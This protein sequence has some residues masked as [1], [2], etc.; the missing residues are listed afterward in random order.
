MKQHYFTSL[1]NKLA[2][3]IGDALTEVTR[4][5]NQGLYDFIRGQFAHDR[6]I[7]G[8]MVFQATYPWE[9][10][11][12]RVD[13]LDYLDP[14][15]RKHI[16][17]GEKPN[18]Y[19]PYKHQD[20]AF[21]SALQVDSD[22]QATVITTGT[23]SGKTEC[24]LTPL[25][26]D[27]VANAD[28]DDGVRA[29]MLYPLNALIN[30]QK[31]RL[32][33]WSQPFG[34]QIRFALYNGNTPYDINSENLRANL[35]EVSDRK[36]IRSAPPQILV[37]NQ[38][39]LEY[40]LVRREDKPILEKSK[41][42]LKWIILDEAHTYIGSQSADIAML[43]KR[44]LLEFEV[45]IE[46]VRFVIT[47][48]TV[49]GE[50]GIASLK[51]FI[52]DLTGL[53]VDKVNVISGN[54]TV[55]ALL[56]PSNNLSLEDVQSHSDAKQVLAQNDTV[57]R[58]FEYMTEGACSAKPLS[59]I[60][61]HMGMTDKQAL[62]W[63]DLVSAHEIMPLKG[64]LFVNTISGI[65]ACINP[66][67]HHKNIHSSDWEYGK[68]FT[69]EVS[70]CQCGAPVYRLVSC[71]KCNQHYHIA[72]IVEKDN[73]QYLVPDK[74]TGSMSDYEYISVQVD[75]DVDD[76]HDQRTYQD[77]QSKSEKSPSFLLTAPDVLCSHVIKA[78]CAKIDNARRVGTEGIVIDLYEAD[79]CPGCGYRSARGAFYSLWDYGAP[80]VLS[81]IVPE[82]FD[83]LSNRNDKGENIYQQGRRFISFTDNRQRTAQINVRLNQVAEFTLC[84]AL[85]Y[86]TIHRSC[87]PKV[88]EE[89]LSDKGL[90]TDDQKIK[91]ALI[92]QYNA[93]RSH[94]P[95]MTYKKLVEELREH[96]YFGKISPYIQGKS[97]DDLNSL[98]KSDIA[99]MLVNR[100]FL[101]YLPSRMTLETTGLCYVTF[102]Y[103]DDID[104]DL[105]QE[106]LLIFGGDAEA[107]ALR[108]QFV[109]LYMQEVIRHENSLPMSWQQR[110][111]LGFDYYGGYIKLEIVDQLKDP[112]SHIEKLRNHRLIHYLLWVIGRKDMLERKP[113]TVNNR[114]KASDEFDYQ[115]QMLFKYVY[116]C[117]HDLIKKHDDS[118]KYF[119]NTDKMRFGLVTDTA[120]CP[121]W[122]VS[123]PYHLKCYTPFYN[124]K[125]IPLDTD[126]SDVLESLKVKPVSIPTYAGDLGD[127]NIFTQDEH[128][129]WLEG[130]KREMDRNKLWF[131]HHQIIFTKPLEDI[132]FVSREHT[133]QIENQQLRNYEDAFNKGEINVLNCSTTMEMGIDLDGIGA[134]VMTN[135]PPH[136]ANYQ[137][138]A[139]RAGR[140][141]E[142][143]TFTLTVCNQTAKDQHIFKHPMALFENKVK[144]KVDL[145]SYTLVRKHINAYLLSC[146]FE[147][148]YIADRS[149]DKFDCKTFF[150]DKTVKKEQTQK[151][152]T[153]YQSFLA[154]LAGV[155]DSDSIRAPIDVWMQ[156]VPSLKGKPI[157]KLIAD[158]QQ[159]IEKVYAEWKEVIDYIH[160]TASVL[161]E[162]DKFKTKLEMDRKR[163]E[164]EYLLAYL[165]RNQFLPAYSFPSNLIELESSDKKNQSHRNRKTKNE[166]Q[167]EFDTISR[168]P[169]REAH[170]AIF[171]YAPG[172]SIVLNNF[173]YETNKIITYKPYDK[174]SSQKLDIVY[175]CNA[176]GH[177]QVPRTKPLENC[178]V[179]DSDKLKKHDVL[180]PKGF[181]Y[182]AKNQHKNITNI[183]RPA[184]Q[185][186]RVKVH[187]PGD[188]ECTNHVGIK[189]KTS[190]I[191]SV[192]ALNKNPLL[193]GRK[194][195]IA[196]GDI[197]FKD[198]LHQCK[199]TDVESG[200]SQKDLSFAAH[201]YTEGYEIKFTHEDSVS[202][203]ILYTLGL[204]LR[205]SLCSILGVNDD[206]VGVVID[207]H[208]YS[209]KLYDINSGGSGFSIQMQS[210][211]DEVL[212]HAMDPKNNLLVCQYC[213]DICN[214]CVGLLDPFIT[215]EKQMGLDR[216]GA[217]ELV[218]AVVK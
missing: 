189:H 21:R 207:S 104:E 174:N 201:Y 101:S 215:E 110:K 74:V 32:K 84:R 61:E 45:S 1:E 187:V 79:G 190:D 98:G 89:W 191:T 63:L 50:E 140:R 8:D 80:F 212:E 183:K 23:G 28:N 166:H 102:E 152:Q 141:G 116:A 46:D 43:I 90:P 131:Y 60:A 87:K 139:G 209:I 165:A 41:G 108:D 69:E 82:L 124:Y 58:L 26:N 132:L 196:C 193:E 200:Y 199:I 56:H 130:Y 29:I 30:S 143:Q 194:V 47:S 138:R 144:P 192:V 206:S 160:K 178:E 52:A 67:C 13:D 122:S 218:K 54:R 164:A 126:V 40:M 24:F 129:Q 86:R 44:I 114:V 176:C 75:E 83:Y 51:Q 195:C 175:E 214:N 31:E 38:S 148:K 135:V 107:A 59:Q 179:C 95:T 99:E 106:S 150:I 128:H 111:L 184:P 72:K 93:E 91:D 76:E 7:I 123:I 71:K 120:L 173:I 208:S 78:D 12:V 171:D 136:P 216:I 25:F 203:Q 88:F 5:K 48:A 37:T 66:R 62:Q 109:H 6:G 3:R 180:L 149:A 14:Q 157:E 36:T 49:G 73:S 185:V 145:R 211:L 162:G 158:C 154:F 217:Y 34:D 16:N 169:S 81:E 127:R 188:F 19:P 35:P 2:N 172:V 4:A 10:A 94:K 153:H 118:G 105:D 147:D 117:C 177:R 198:G 20:A 134:V 202:P 156:E 65:Y 85:V 168:N 115:V 142:Y 210:I 100:E 151:E 113:D 18:I 64:H 197:Y 97:D 15:F 112:V 137:Q 17:S 159:R 103:D 125:K 96:S 205:R 181:I 11:N 161:R 119:I 186:D 204:V 22:Y 42:K 146:Y 92:G 167:N 27:L 55:E 53:N 170:K 70:H 121:V 133:A 77:N 213:A 163:Y 68:V 182:D 33:K 39:M 9:S 57:H 155:A